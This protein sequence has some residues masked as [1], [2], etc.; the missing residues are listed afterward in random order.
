MSNTNHISSLIIKHLLG[1]LTTEENQ[2][3]TAWLASSDAN[4]ELFQQLTETASLQ[5]ELASYAETNQRI[6]QMVYDRLQQQDEDDSIPFS[7]KYSNWRRWA[8]AAAAILLLAF[9]STWYLFKHAAPARQ[10]VAQQKPKAQPILP[11][12]NKATLTLGDGSIVNLD[13][14]ANGLISNQ[15]NVKVVKSNNGLLTYQSANGKQAATV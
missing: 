12:G 3:L 8:V 4:Q 6:Q 9:G 5:R 2:A 15:G 10:E 11:G 7:S 1:D 13:S 14:T